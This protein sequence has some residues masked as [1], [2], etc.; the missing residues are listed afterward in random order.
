[1]GSLES[2]VKEAVKIEKKEEQAIRTVIEDMP[3]QSEQLLKDLKALMKINRELIGLMGDLDAGRDPLEVYD[4]AKSL[5]SKQSKYNQQLVNEIKRMEKRGQINGDVLEKIEAMEQKLGELEQ[6][7]FKQIKNQRPPVMINRSDLDS[8]LSLVVD[9]RLPDARNP[10][11]KGFET[12]GVFECKKNDKGY[13]LGGFTPAPSEKQQRT[14]YNPPEKIDRRLKRIVKEIGGR[15]NIALAHSHPPGHYT[16]SKNDIRYI[17]EEIGLKG[18]SGLL[19]VI[20][21][22]KKGAG[23][24]RSNFFV[25]AEVFKNK[26]D[27]LNLPVKVSGLSE[28]ELDGQ[29]PLI[30]KYNRC[31][32]KASMDGGRWTDYL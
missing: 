13:Y 23:R 25:C 31:V 17:Q 27:T 3:A 1:M 5:R 32:R 26:S 28:K 12:G 21:V 24:S 2:K 8:F 19:G 16:H 6:K 20:A 29:Y 30:H 11:E 7:A 22:R 15:A 9:A 10:T 4:D 14:E 18:L